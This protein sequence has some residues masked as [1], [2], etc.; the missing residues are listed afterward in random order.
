MNSLYKTLSS[1]ARKFDT[2]NDTIKNRM[3]ALGLQPAAVLENGT[4][5][6]DN[7]SFEQLRAVL[8]PAP[9]PTADLTHR[10]PG[11]AVC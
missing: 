6:I 9:T 8:A 10:E 7:D 5:L 3:R 11:T 2:S 4:I 1:V